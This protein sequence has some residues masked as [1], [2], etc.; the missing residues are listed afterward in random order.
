MKRT[1]P[2]CN[3]KGI[4]TEGKERAGFPRPTAGGFPGSISIAGGERRVASGALEA[5]RTGSTPAPSNRDRSTYGQKGPP[6]K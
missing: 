1:A 6:S 3:P 4:W 5:S 2:V